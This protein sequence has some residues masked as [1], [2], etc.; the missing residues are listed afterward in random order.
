MIWLYIIFYWPTT[1]KQKL[2]ISD[3]QSGLIQKHQ[4]LKEA[5]KIPFRWTAY[6]VLD[7]GQVLVEKSDV[8]SFGVLI[9]EMFHFANALPYED[10]NIWNVED[11]KPFLANGHRLEKPKLCPESIHSRLLECWDLVP[12]NRPP[13]RALISAKN[14]GGGAKAP[15]APPPSCDGPGVLIIHL[16]IYHLDLS[17]PT[18][19]T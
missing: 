17:P 7:N 16:S 3:F 12:V 4:N 13:F 8:W 2:W 18:F 10:E 19:W 9:W 5:S 6:E 15:P 1:W 14:W 11:L